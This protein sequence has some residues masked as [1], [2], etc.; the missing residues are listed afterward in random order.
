MRIALMSDLHL[1]FQPHIL[2]D[3]MGAEVL[4]LAGDITVV[5]GLEKSE[6]SPYY[7]TRVATE[8]FFKQ[9]CGMFKLVIWVFGNHEFY[10]GR[11][12]KSRKLAKEFASQFENLHILEDEFVVYKGI[13]FIGSTFWTDMDKASP[14]TMMD[15]RSFMNDY[16]QITDDSHGFKKLHPNKTVSTHLHS[17]VNIRALTVNNSF[18]KRVL[19]THHAPSKLSQHAKY[20]ND[21][22]SGAYTSNCHDLLELFDLAVHGHIHQSFD[23]MVGK[24]RVVCHPKGYPKERLWEPHYQPKI[25]EI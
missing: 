17:K 20:V 2:E 4:I 10:Q 9:A 24:T 21:T 3:N 11:W 22:L 6:T 19:I 8:R 1:E 5:A 23:Y 25:L 13:Q 18:E 12:L 15:A 14:L 7:T 16:K